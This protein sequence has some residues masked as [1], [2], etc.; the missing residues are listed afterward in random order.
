MICNLPFLPICQF[1]N[2][3]VNGETGRVPACYLSHADTLRGQHLRKKQNPERPVEVISSLSDVSSKHKNGGHHGPPVR[4]LQ[5]GSHVGSGH[6]SNAP[7]PKPMLPFTNVTK[8]TP[9]SSTNKPKFGPVDPA[10]S[11]PTPPPAANK[12][13]V[14]TATVAGRSAA[15]DHTSSPSGYSSQDSSGEEDS[16][17]DEEKF[18][19]NGKG[20]PPPRSGTI[21]RSVWVRKLCTSPCVRIGGR[22]CT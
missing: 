15:G 11:S 13:K 4:N 9:P 20:G 8:P 16:F 17:P 14:A 21:G 5:A 6:D 7:A 22:Q 2:Y 1:C 12:P 3:R 19:P 18:L 10:R